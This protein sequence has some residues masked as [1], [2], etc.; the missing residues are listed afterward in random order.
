AVDR[1]GMGLSTFNVMGNFLTFAD[2]VKQLTEFLNIIN[3]SV[4]CWSGGGPYALAIAHQYPALI[5]SVFI[6]CGFSRSFDKEVLRQMGMN[7]W[8][9]RSA[10]YSP[11]LLRM[12]LNVIKRK[13][14]KKIVPQ[15]W[16]GLPYVDY[17]L[18]KDP[19]HLNA[20]ARNTIKEACRKGARGA[21]FEAKSYYNEFGFQLSK[22][23]QPVHFWWGTEDMTVIRL[24]AEAVERQIPNS[25]MHY[26]NGE[27]HLSVYVNYMKEVF[28]EISRIY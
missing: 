26:K 15:K 17:A 2:D 10:K 6:I 28:Q 3:C 24:H 12:A 18:L 20:V 27:G 25:V 1:S 7:K 14:L 4:L 8:Y 16:T 22:I 13:H 19:V 11:W 9:F 21:V 23:Q 5:K